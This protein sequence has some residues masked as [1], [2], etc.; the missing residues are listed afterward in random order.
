MRPLP[1][2]LASLAGEIRAEPAGTFA[3]LAQAEAN[4]LVAQLRGSRRL[5]LLPPSESAK[6]EGPAGAITDV[7]D[8]DQLDLF[9]RAAE[10]RLLEIDLE[11]G[12]LLFLPLG[13]W[14]QS[15]ALDFSAAAWFGDFRWPNPSLAG[16]EG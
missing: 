8:P 15:T 10:A 3:P 13:W 12:E 4:R 14:H 11:A 9:P 6:L 1:A 2:L 5:A 16:G 7:H